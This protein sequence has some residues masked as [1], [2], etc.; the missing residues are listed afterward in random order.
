MKGVGVVRTRSGD[1]SGISRRRG[2]LLSGKTS[3][4]TMI[5]FLIGI[6]TLYG[7]GTTVFQSHFAGMFISDIEVDEITGKKRIRRRPERH[8]QKLDPNKPT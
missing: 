8:R 4:T 6:L 1:I 3:Q 2:Q 7:M 5:G